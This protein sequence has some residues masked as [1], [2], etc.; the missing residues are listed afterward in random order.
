MA[1]DRDLDPLPS[2][3]KSLVG[4][5]PFTA[6]LPKPAPIAEAD[7]A[8]RF[9]TER[10]DLDLTRLHAY[11]FVGDRFVEVG[12]VFEN[13]IAIYPVNPAFP[14]TADTY[15]LMDAPKAGWLAATF[16]EPVQEVGCRV[17][18]AR[19][20]VMTACD[21]AGDPIAQAAL[22]TANLAPGADLPSSSTAAGQTAPPSMPNTP[23][24]VCAPEIHR[25][26]F[27]VHDGHF[28]LSQ[29]WMWRDRADRV[30]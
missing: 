16:L 30:D 28:T 26:I 24:S 23:L 29:F 15:V 20:L 9:P 18:S 12:V 19:G 8:G 4:P 13:A 21:A 5:I 25:V 3:G 17:T 7:D 10:I 11:E 27:S 14:T 6:D 22:T 1:N 2:M